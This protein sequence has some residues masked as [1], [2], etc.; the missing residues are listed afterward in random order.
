MVRIPCCQ[1]VFWRNERL[2]E[3]GMGCWTEGWVHDSGQARG[4]IHLT[5]SLALA[6][7]LK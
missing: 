1:V 5:A 4:E 3:G 2:E 6:F 7:Y